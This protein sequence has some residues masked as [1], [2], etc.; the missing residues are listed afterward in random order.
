MSIFVFIIPEEKTDVGE[1]QEELKG[2]LAEVASQ[3]DVSHASPPTED[4]E[5]TQNQETL[6]DVIPPETQQP[7][8]Q[9]S[10]ART[11]SGRGRPPK[12]TV[13]TAQKKT[14]VKKEE[15]KAAQNAPGSQGD[16]SDTD[17]TPS[18]DINIT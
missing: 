18:K 5:P 10:P 9:P 12:T 4:K 7:V 17:Y 11:H 14:S 1:Q 15:E 6:K 13:V 8:C 2:D 3:A 16:P